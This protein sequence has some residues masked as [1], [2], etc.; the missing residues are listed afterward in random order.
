MTLANRFLSRSTPVRSLGPNG[1]VMRPDPDSFGDSGLLSTSIHSLRN[2]RGTCGR[3]RLSFIST[4]FGCDRRN[5][6]RRQSSGRRAIS[7]HFIDRARLSARA[8]SGATRQGYR[9]NQSGARHRALHASS[10]GTLRTSFKARATKQVALAF[11]CS[12]RFSASF[13]PIWGPH[14]RRDPAR[15]TC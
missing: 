1:T 6:H 5:A 10:I 14:R 3:P 2:V 4:S 7:G 9:G 8:Q 11:R 12:S 13:N 15:S